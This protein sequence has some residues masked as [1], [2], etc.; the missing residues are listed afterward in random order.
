MLFISKMS[1]ALPH[2]VIMCSLLKYQLQVIP[3]V[4]Y[5]SASPRSLKT[6]YHCCYGTGMELM[7]VQRSNTIVL[8]INKVPTQLSAV[9]RC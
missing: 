6:R 8:D 5:S 7:D 2:A 3:T 9:E 4:K 1:S